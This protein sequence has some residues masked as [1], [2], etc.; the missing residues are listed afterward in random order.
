MLVNLCD[1][2]IR[3]IIIIVWLESFGRQRFFVCFLYYDMKKK[4][5]MVSREFFR[6]T[7]LYWCESKVPIETKSNSDQLKKF[8]LFFVFYHQ[9]LSFP[10]MIFQW[11]NLSFLN[12]LKK[13]SNNNNK[14][15]NTKKNW[16]AKHLSFNSW[17][18]LFKMCSCK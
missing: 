13:N 16:H 1:W 14:K 9:L 12:L 15:Y 7:K 18:N 3:I 2:P 4:E 17:L 10:R 6:S 11:F 8:K 5:V